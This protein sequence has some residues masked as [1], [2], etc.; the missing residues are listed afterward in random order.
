MINLED[1]DEITSI[2]INLKIHPKMSGF[3][4]IR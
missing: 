3:D 1:K 4:Y 2:L